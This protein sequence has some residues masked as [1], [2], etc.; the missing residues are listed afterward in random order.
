MTNDNGIGNRNTLVFGDH[1]GCFGDFNIED[2]ICKHH[3]VL[4]LRCAIERDQND[5]IEIIED[6]IL[7]DSMFVIQ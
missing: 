2:R 6:M 4:S 3:C 5:Q 7:P 1:L